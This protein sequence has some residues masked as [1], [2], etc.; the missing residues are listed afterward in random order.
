MRTV[1]LWLFLTA[2]L[3]ACQDE[4]QYEYGTVE[5]FLTSSAASFEKVVV[6]IESLRL[7]H[8]TPNN[9][10]AEVNLPDY[11]SGK[12]DLVEYSNGES[13]QLASTQ[14]APGKLSEIIIKFGENSITTNE[15]VFDL[16]NTSLQNTE[17]VVKVDEELNYGSNQIIYLCFDAKNSVVESSGNYYLKP[18]IKAFTPEST[19]SIEGFIQPVTSN[20]VVAVSW[21][22]NVM[23]TI[24]EPNGYFCFLGLDEGIYDLTVT[25]QAPFLEKSIEG[26][27]VSANE[28][29]D[30]GTIQLEKQ[31]AL[32]IS[33]DLNINPATSEGNRFEMQ[34][35]DGLIDIDVIY[36]NGDGF[37]Y[38][39]SATE[40]KIMPK[41]Q[42]RTL[43]IDGVD[44][45]LGTNARYTIT[46]NDTPMDVELRNTKSGNGSWWIN[47]TGENIV[48]LPAPNVS[49]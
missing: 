49:K 48:I 18:V 37:T 9:E 43:T 20:P 2:L 36:E 1:L 5:V 27:G 47:I 22:D 7:I 38:N 25:P 39:G 46:S 13:I 29:T 4:T 23:E 28:K 17:I 6:E 24:T 31:V 19:G 30:L 32:T 42:G 40:I 16:K 44:V 8:L 12:Y 41:A 21:G 10:R 33:G 11:Q 35:P 45:Q 15:G 34:T 26:I 3:I 14:I